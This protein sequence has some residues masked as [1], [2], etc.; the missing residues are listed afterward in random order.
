[1]WN[2]LF[3]GTGEFLSKRGGEEGAREGSVQSARG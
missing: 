3:K 2:H 1:M